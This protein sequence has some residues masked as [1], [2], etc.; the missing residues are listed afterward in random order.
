[1]KYRT[2]GKTNAK[3]SAL[4][5]GAMRLP[6]KGNESDVDE[7]QSIEMIRYAVD[8]GVNYVDTA[9]VYHGGNGEGVVGK[10]LA[11]GYREQFL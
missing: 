8:R 1:M 4:G 3:V 10:A 9:Y 7:A 6:T 2:L 11:G 5:F